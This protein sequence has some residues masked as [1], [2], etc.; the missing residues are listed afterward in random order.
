MLQINSTLFVTVIKTDFYVTNNNKIMKTFSQKYL[1]IVFYKMAANYILFCL[2]NTVILYAYIIVRQTEAGV[3]L[4][5][6]QFSESHLVF[7][8]KQEYYAFYGYLIIILQTSYL[9]DLKWLVL[10]A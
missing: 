3:T 1:Q 2:D 4:W 9:V 7:V 8:Y 10:G 6:G 5:M